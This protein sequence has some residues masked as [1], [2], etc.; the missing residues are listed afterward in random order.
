M[1]FAGDDNLLRNSIRFSDKRES[2]QLL[3][4]SVDGWRRDQCFAFTSTTGRFFPVEL[5]IFSTVVCGGRLPLF[6]LLH[7]IYGRLSRDDGSNAS[8]LLRL[9]ALD[10]FHDTAVERR[11]IQ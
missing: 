1:G 7:H 8:V 10:E 4:E 3:S 9:A 5:G 6:V 11:W 2:I